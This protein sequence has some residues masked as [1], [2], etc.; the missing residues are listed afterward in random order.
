MAS[1]LLL[2]EKAMTSLKGERM[3]GESF[4][5]KIGFLRAGWWIIHL[6]GISFVYAFG[7]I[8]WR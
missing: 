2:M 5:K 1:L 7:H 4:S 8:F 6:T 3:N